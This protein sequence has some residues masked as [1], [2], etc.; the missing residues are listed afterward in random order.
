MKKITNNEMYIKNNLWIIG[1]W[2]IASDSH[3]VYFQDIFSL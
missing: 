1:G 3:S 2:K